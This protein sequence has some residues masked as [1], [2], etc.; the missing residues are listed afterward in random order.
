MTPEKR[1]S[2]RGTL[3]AGV[4]HD[5]LGTLLAR[6]ATRHFSKLA[7]G[8][9]RLTDAGSVYAIVTHELKR[10]HRHWHSRLAVSEEVGD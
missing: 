7:I 3:S 6:R 10:R 4:A 5:F 2:I 1:R 8:E 9:L